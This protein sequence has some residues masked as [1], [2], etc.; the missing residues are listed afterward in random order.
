MPLPAGET[1]IL[2]TAG[3][4]TAHGTEV[5]PG[6]WLVECRGETGLRVRRRL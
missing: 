2:D 1:I 5:G 3:H 6:R 4:R